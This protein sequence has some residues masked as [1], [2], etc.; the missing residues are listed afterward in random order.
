MLREI[1]ILRVGVL[2]DAGYELHQHDAI[3]R[4][5]GMSEELLAAIRN[6]PADP[7]LDERKRLVVRF[8]DDVVANVRPS[9]DTFEPLRAMLSARELNE[10]VMTIGCYMA[11]CRY[12]ET[13]G[14]DIED[15]DSTVPLD[16][17]V[18]YMLVA[19]AS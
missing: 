12:L 16:V 10:L 11:V 8:T 17:R 18:C 3:G 5:I 15:P 9:D 6:G 19:H 4:R 14:V 1:A 13:F 2:S 7:A